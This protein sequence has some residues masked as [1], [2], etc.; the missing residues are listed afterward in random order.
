MRYIGMTLKN[1]E[2]Q[3]RKLMLIDNWYCYV[4]IGLNIILRHFLWK[5]KKIINGFYIFR[6][7]NVKNLL[8]FFIIIILKISVNEN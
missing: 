1:E 4:S 5:N 6:K 2:R 7:N 8:I 3:C